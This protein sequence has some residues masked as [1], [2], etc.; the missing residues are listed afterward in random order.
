MLVCRCTG[1]ASDGAFSTKTGFSISDS[2]LPSETSALI[3][4]KFLGASFI[5]ASDK[6]CCYRLLQRERLFS[7]GDSLSAFIPGAGG[8][9]FTLS[10]LVKL[11]GLLN[12]ESSFEFSVRR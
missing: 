5:L 8:S 6:F 4:I 9:D 11:K 2:L 3:D 1:G 12:E 10:Y 7:G